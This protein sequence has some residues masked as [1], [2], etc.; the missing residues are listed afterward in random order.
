MRKEVLL[1]SSRRWGTEARPKRGPDPARPL[2]ALSRRACEPL[3]PGSPCPPSALQGL[4]RGARL[5]HRFSVSYFGSG[6]GIT[7]R[8]LP[9]PRPGRGERGPQRYRG[10][11]GGRVKAGEQRSPVGR[12]VRPSVCP[13]VLPPSAFL[14]CL[15]H[16]VLFFFFGL[17]RRRGAEALAPGALPSRSRAEVPLFPSSPIISPSPIISH[18]NFPISISPSSP[19]ISPL[20]AFQ[21]PWLCSGSLIPGTCQI[22]GAFQGSAAA[23]GAAAWH[24]FCP[25]SPSRGAPP[26]GP[27]PRPGSGCAAG[28]DARRHPVCEP[29]PPRHLLPR[30]LLILR[31]K[32]RT[33]SWITFLPWSRR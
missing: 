21:P 8:C 9:Q 24:K 3:P 5:S 15:P 31:L 1:S 26:R 4:H 16:P 29:C 28:E 7:P 2:V 25:L 14:P 20:P 12:F 30:K 23:G 19:I 22:S 18:L 13:S 33:A 6:A 10:E 27:P 11:V 17:K 32:N